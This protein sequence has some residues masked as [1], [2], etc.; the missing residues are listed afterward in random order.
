MRCVACGS[1][2]EKN[3]VYHGDEGTLYEGKPVCESCYDE[4][5]PAATV[6]YNRNEQP[7]VISGTRNETSGNFGVKWYATDPWRGYYETCSDVYSLVNSAE[8]L[9]YHESERMLKEF[10]ARIR[11]LFDEHGIEYARVFSKTSNV[12][13]QNYDLYVKKDQI[14]PAVLLVARAKSEVNYDDPKWS[15]NIVFNENT[16]RRLAD[17]FPERKIETDFDAV[18]LIK[19]LHEGGQNALDDLK[20]RMKEKEERK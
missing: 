1:K 4:D 7:L 3:E 17:L 11:G 6:F 13:Y 9:A 20:K 18:E 8:L 14:L 16:L 12:F 19:E 15:K 10:D 2:I 5:E